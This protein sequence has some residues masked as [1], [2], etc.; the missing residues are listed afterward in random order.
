[1]TQTEE[2]QQARR[3]AEAKYGFFKHAGVYAAV[4]ALLVV[5][6]MV[7][8]PQAFWFIWPLVGW[9][10]AVALHGVRVYLLADKNTVLDALTEQEL[11]QSGAGRT[12]KDWGRD[13]AG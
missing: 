8:S 3:R 13:A 5:I 9:G 2:Y 10:L 4:M 7:T 12:S 11:R 1:M 6:N